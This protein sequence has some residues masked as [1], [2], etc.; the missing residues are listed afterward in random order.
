MQHA[1]PFSITLILVLVT[2]KLILKDK[3]KEVFTSSAG[4]FELSIYVFIQF[5]KR[6]SLKVRLKFVFF[7][8]NSR[9]DI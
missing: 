8:Y 5:I 2:R 9:Y 1:L 7:L 3:Q 4:M 6:T